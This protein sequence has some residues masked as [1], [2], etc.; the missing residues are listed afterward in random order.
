MK[1]ELELVKFYKKLLI[2]IAIKSW[3]SKVDFF[4]KKCIILYTNGVIVMRKC[5]VLLYHNLKFD[6]VNSLIMK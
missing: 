5:I 2:F 3:V 6:C 1:T 4:I